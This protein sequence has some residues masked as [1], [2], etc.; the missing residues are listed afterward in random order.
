MIRFDRV[1]S[2]FREVKDPFRL[3]KVSMQFSRKLLAAHDLL[4]L[5]QLRQRELEFLDPNKVKKSILLARKKKKSFW[6]FENQK[7]EIFSS[8]KF[9]LIFS[10]KQ[11]ENDEKLLA[12]ESL[13]LFK[14]FQPKPKA[15]YL[16]FT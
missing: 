1:A 2:Q 9:L 4:L 10:V 5:E 14:A 8:F 16:I 12:L 13:E 3:D 15:F 7:R 11:P 6:L